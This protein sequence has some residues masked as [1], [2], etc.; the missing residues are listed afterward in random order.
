[1]WQV[2]QAYCTYFPLE[3]SKL[4]SQTQF[5]ESID[6]PF[7]RTLLPG[8]ITGSGILIREQKMLLI[9]HRYLKEWFQ[10]GGH[11]DAGESPPDGAIREV[12]EETGWQSILSSLYPSKLPFDIDVHVIPA[13]P[14]K[15]EPEHLH[16][17]FAYLLEPIHHGQASD[18]ETVAWVDL[19]MCTAP[20]LA[21][22]VEKYQLL[23]RA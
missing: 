2:I 6:E 23:K 21:R 18:P 11:I 13:N 1:M 7:P 5:L 12:L 8:H 22:C 16:I 10:P 4:L 9:Q 14:I 17:D 20:R 19:A 3:A 15:N